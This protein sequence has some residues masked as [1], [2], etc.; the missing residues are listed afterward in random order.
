MCKP[1]ISIITI[2]YN[3]EETIEEAIRSVLAQTYPHIEYLIIDGLSTDN[4]MTIVQQYA[5]QIDYILSETDKGISDAFNKGIQAATGDIIGICN[6]T[7]IL[8]PDA[9]QCIADAYEEGIDVYRASETIQNPQTG[10]DYVIHPSMRIPRIPMFTNICHMGCFFSKK[11]MES[12]GMYDTSFSS[13]MDLELLRR[14]FYHGARFKKVNAN[15]GVFRLG[16]VSQCPEY[17][18]VK[19]YKEI[20]LRY[21]GQGL[22]VLIFI[23]YQYVRRAIKRLVNLFGKDIANRIRS[24]QEKHNI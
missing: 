5:E 19:E 22:D 3:S 16:G 13:L 15:V 4:T 21:G 7:D 10:Y 18:R 20:I 11:C 12:Y 1:K 6:S 24:F 23:I 14:L 9:L 17:N 2:S 8:F